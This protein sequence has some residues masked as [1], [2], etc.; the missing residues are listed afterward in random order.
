MKG[1]LSLIHILGQ[2]GQQGDAGHGGAELAFT[3]GAVAVLLFFKPAEGLD[4]GVLA[5]RGAAVFRD[6]RHA[7]VQVAALGKNAGKDVYKRQ[8]P[9]M[10]QR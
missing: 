3:P 1:T 5:L 10:I 6:A 9:W 7:V 4:H 8:I 2:V